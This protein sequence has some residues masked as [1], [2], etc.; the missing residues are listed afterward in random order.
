MT[1]PRRAARPADLS[2]CARMHIQAGLI[3][4]IHKGHTRELVHASR[5]RTRSNTILSATMCALSLFTAIVSQFCE[6]ATAVHVPSINP[7]SINELSVCRSINRP[8]F[9]PELRMQCE[10]HGRPDNGLSQYTIFFFEYSGLLTAF[11]AAEESKL[12]I[13]LHDEL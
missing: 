11:L 10:R 9:T 6:D 5:T 3:E 1:I 4:T 13:S 2:L 8:Q 12:D 7:A